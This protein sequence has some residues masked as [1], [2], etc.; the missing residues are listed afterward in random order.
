MKM[1]GCKKIV[2]TVLITAL[3]LTFA[4]ILSPLSASAEEGKDTSITSC[5]AFVLYDKTHK[6]YVIEE[7]GFAIV[8]TSTSAKIMT[9]LIACEKLADRLDETVTVT[10]KMISDASGYSMRLKSGENIKIRDLLY[11]A[12]CGSYNDA[13]YALAH[14]VGGD[15]AGFVAMMNTKA[16]ELGAK[17]TKYTNPLGYPD[18]EA[19]VT[20]AYDTLKIALAASENQLYMEISSAN[21]YT[22][23]ATDMTA[24][25]EFYNRNYLISSATTMQYHNEKCRGMNAGISGEAGGWS[26]VTLVEDDGADYICVL[27]GGAD[28]VDG[29]SFPAYEEVNNH[30]NKICK[31][32]NSYT[33][34]KKG[35]QLGTTK[36]ALTGIT[37]DEAPYIAKDD[38]TVYIPTTS[39]ANIS[40]NIILND[41]IKAPL[42]AGDVI[43]KVIITSHG[44][45]VGE[46]EIAIKDSHEANGVMKVINDLGDYT[47]SRAF[48]ISVIC[49]VILLSISLFI[50][51]YMPNA[52]SKKKYRRY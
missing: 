50:Y 28:T 23:A 39:D 47:K 7:N 10:E 18:N 33:V 35:T 4:A 11:G 1:N 16:L 40:Y 46:G 5:A 41:E 51:F 25:R 27:L 43:G 12:I 19:M 13:A 49:F 44:Q 21:K 2:C 6:K 22:A 29:V 34:F 26:I 3:L 20:T 17:A 31:E 42:N 45:K 9:G 52:F 15:S 48:I 14:I 37:T 30:I 38:I 8:N 24:A 36:V 32:Y